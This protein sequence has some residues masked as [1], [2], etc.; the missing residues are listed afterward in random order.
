M[1]TKITN[2]AARIVFVS[3]NSGTTLRLSPTTTSDEIAD[4]EIQDNA[5]VEKLQK[6]RLIAVEQITDQPLSSKPKETKSKSET[7]AKEK[8]AEPKDKGQ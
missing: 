5:K 7:P 4:V 2:L 8:S 1:P 6:L 3:L